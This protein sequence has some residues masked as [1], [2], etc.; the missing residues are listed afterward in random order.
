[1]S[2]YNIKMIKSVLNEERIDYNILSLIYK[3]LTTTIK[4]SNF[5]D[6]ISLQPLRCTRSSDVVT[7]ACP[8]LYS[9]LKVPPCLTSSLE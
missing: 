8:P 9:S 2:L 6:L 5:D 1:M 4:S 3:V 7:L